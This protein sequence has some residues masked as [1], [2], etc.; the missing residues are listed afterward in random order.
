MRTEKEIRAEIR[1]LDKLTPCSESG[2]VRQEQAIEHLKWV[3][4]ID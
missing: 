4:E 1:R 2:K 3:L